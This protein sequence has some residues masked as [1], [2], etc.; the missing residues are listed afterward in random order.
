MQNLSLTIFIHKKDEIIVFYASEIQ[1][2]YVK[3]KESNL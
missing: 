2:I 3:N 1:S